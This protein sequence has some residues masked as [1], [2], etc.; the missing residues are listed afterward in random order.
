MIRCCRP[1]FLHC[2]FNVRDSRSLISNIYNR[3]FR[4]NF[5]INL[6]TAGMND[7]IHLSFIGSNSNTSDYIC[8]NANFL[9]QPL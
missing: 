1:A 3:L 6:T 5:S 9:Q 8:R 7:Y 2:Q 4:K